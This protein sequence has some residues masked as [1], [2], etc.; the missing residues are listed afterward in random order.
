MTCEGFG[1]KL[2]MLNPRKHNVPERAME[3]L[4]FLI[5]GED[6]ICLGPVCEILGPDWRQN[7]PGILATALADIVAGLAADPLETSSLLAIELRFKQ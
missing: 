2:S 4:A 1:V 5:I 3:Q 6:E 7:G